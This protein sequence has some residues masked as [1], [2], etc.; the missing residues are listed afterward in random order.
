MKSIFP[1]ARFFG[2]VSTHQARDWFDLVTQID[3]ELARYKFELVEESVYIF[4][5]TSAPEESEFQVFRNVI[6]A[7]Q[8]VHE[9]FLLKDWEQKNVFKTKI[10]ARDWDQILEEIQKIWENHCRSGMVLVPG[11]WLKAS[12]KINSGLDLS[13]EVM[14]HE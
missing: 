12:R 9:A 7:K 4:S 1:N 14:F 3:N 13:L 11:F 8:N 2:L 6:G 5:P 10:L